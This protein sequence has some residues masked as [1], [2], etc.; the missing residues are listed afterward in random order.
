M[1]APGR[2]G[3]GERRVRGVNGG[4]FRRSASGASNPVSVLGEPGVVEPDPIARQRPVDVDGERDRLRPASEDRKSVVL[5]K[6]AEVG[7]GRTIKK[8]RAREDGQWGECGP[9]FAGG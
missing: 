1:R 5:G 8:K 7:G 2:A 3:A 9:I 4:Q 6:A